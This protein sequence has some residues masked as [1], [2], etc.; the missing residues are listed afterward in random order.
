MLGW[1]DGEEGGSRGQ[2]GQQNEEGLESCYLWF[3]LTGFLAGP[4]LAGQL[5]GFSRY[6]SASL[7]VCSYIF[8][9]MDMMQSLV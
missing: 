9:D 6:T 8:A 4:V 7:F 2:R 1:V 5:T 3:V